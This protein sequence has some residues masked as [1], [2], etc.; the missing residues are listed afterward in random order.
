MQHAEI[1]AAARPQH[2]IGFAGGAGEVGAIH[3]RHGRQRNIEALVGAAVE[4]GEG[5]DAIGDAERFHGFCRLCRC[6]HS[7]GNIDPGDLRATTGHLARVAALATPQIDDGAAGEVRREGEEHRVVERLAQFVP[8]GADMTDPK[9]RVAIP[10]FGH[11]DIAAHHAFRR[12]FHRHAR[13]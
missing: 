10:G 2:A 6:N 12:A 1:E 3:Q 13:T 8:P 7:P 5:G 11:L 4:P 9:A